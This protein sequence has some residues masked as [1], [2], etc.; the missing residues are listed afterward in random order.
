[1]SHTQPGTRRRLKRG[2]DAYDERAGSYPP[3]TVG[4]SGSDPVALTCDSRWSPSAYAWPAMRLTL[5]LLIIFSLRTIDVGLSTIRIVF[6][7]RSRRVPAAALGFAESL[8]WVIA[9]T[10]VLGGLDDPARMVAFAAGFAAGTYVGSRV[11]EW[12]ALGQSLVRIVAPVESP[13][14]APMLRDRGYGATVLNGDGLLGEVRVI[15]SV[16]PRKDLGKVTRLLDEAS[17]DAYI[18]IDQTSSVDLARHGRNVRR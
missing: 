13:S 16:V 6:L 7:G 8:I 9:F 5:D 1:M 17:P 3:P 10:R 2:G 15:F 18:T 14:V 11:E 12:L 4:G